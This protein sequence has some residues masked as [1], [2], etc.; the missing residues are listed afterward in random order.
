MF[1]TY[2]SQPGSHSRDLGNATIAAAAA[3]KRNFERRKSTKIE[4]PQRVESLS[5]DAWIKHPFRERRCRRCLT[6]RE[7]SC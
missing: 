5:A 4:H 7:Q 1:F 3:S 6:P 2:N